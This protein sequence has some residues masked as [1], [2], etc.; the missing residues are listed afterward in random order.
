MKDGKV[1]EQGTHG[2]LLRKGGFYRELYDSQF[3]K[4]V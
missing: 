3:A 4:I 1:I 2:E